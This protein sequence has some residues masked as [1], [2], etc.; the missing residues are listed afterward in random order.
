PLALRLK[1]RPGRQ[2]RVG[3]Q[4]PLHSWTIAAAVWI[5]TDTPVSVMTTRDLR[6][7]REPD[8]RR[9]PRPSIL[10]P[11][12]L[13]CWSTGTSSHLLEPAP[14]FSRGPRQHLDLRVLFQL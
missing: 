3:R 13:R 12:P 7:R 11:C 8:R 14:V 5:A 4:R 2:F 6:Q 1:A 9:L 10:R